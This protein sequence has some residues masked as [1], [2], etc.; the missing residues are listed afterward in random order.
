MCDG[1][2]EISWMEDRFEEHR[3]HLKAVAYRVLGSQAEADDAVQEAWLRF[4]R[5]DTSEVANL[6]GW[7]TTVVGRIALDMLRSRGSRREEPLGAHVPDPVVSRWEA[8]PEDQVVLADSVGLALLV[9][10]ETLGPAERLAFVLHDL[11]GMSFDEIAPIVDRTPAA[12]RQLASRAR[13]R[14]R[15]QAPDGDTDL[16]RQREIVEAFIAASQGGDF[17]AM[18]ALL[19]PDVVLRVDAGE[20]GI[21]TSRVVHGAET[22]V[23]QALAYSRFSYASRPVL[24]NGGAGIATVPDGQPLSIM[25]LTIR[26]GKIVEI[27][28]LSDPERLQQIDPAVFD[29]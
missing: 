1:M 23:R 29:G 5:A 22:V 24:V 4:N 3:A 14:V 9:V 18:L 16:A 2:D 15:G 25:G 13:R 27:D 6:G 17:D 26:R 10:L 12:A 21:G 20:L 28:I 7:L 8:G 19:D 11:F